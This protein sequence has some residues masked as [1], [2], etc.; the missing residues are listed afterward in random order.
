M[1][2]FID[3]VFLFVY[4]M[5]LLYLKLPD[6]LNTSYLTHKLFIFI[7]TFIYFYMI[8]LI[9][10]IRDKCKIDPYELLQSSVV[11]ALCSVIGYSIYVDMLYMESTKLYFGAPDCVDPLKRYA[12]IALIIVF[13]VALIQLMQLLFQAESKT[14][15]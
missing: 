1:N 7:E 2:I 10:K 3:A 5:A 4:L 14:K 12:V 15:C 9:K 6:V 11:W 13:F 8:Q